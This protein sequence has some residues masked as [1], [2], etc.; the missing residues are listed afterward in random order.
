MP[1]LKDLHA[2]IREKNADQVAEILQTNPALAAER[3]AGSPSAVLFAAYVGDPAILALVR[4]KATLDACEATALGD[5]GQLVKILDRDQSQANARSG[6]G[7]TALHLAGFF[8]KRD[9]ADLLLARGASVSAV[10]GTPDKNQPLQAAL[11]GACDTAIVTALVAH[12]ADVNHA[13][14]TGYTPIHTAA[15]RGNEGLVR[16]LIGAGARVNVKMDDGKTPADIAA[17]KGHTKVAELLA[18]LAGTA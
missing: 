7:W 6:D 1:S 9:A 3:P 11:A 18:G 12:G 10:S 16:F 17:A 4:A 2:A 5:V 13:G 14:A 15:S 8:G